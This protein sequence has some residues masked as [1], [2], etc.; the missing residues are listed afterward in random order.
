MARHRR[1]GGAALAGLALGAVVVAP[2]CEPK[3]VSATV[4]CSLVSYNGEPPRPQQ[5]LRATGLALNRNYQN[6]IY[7]DLDNGPFTIDIGWSSREGVIELPTFSDRP[8][9]YFA[10]TIYD[11][12]NA[13]GRWDP[14][15]D[16]TYLHAE[17]TITDCPQTITM[18]PK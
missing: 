8:P 10:W 3:P 4:T 16:K 15:V 17:G 14:D 11:D 1:M 13:N 9:V 6:W 7:A 12:L 18:S 2:A 5:K